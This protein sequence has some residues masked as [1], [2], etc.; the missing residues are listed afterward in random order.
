MT[1]RTISIIMELLESEIQVLEYRIKTEGRK[2]T[3][4]EEIISD[5]KSKLSFTK[6]AFYQFSDHEFTC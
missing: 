4:D 5:L 3:P 6:T 2:E 1:A